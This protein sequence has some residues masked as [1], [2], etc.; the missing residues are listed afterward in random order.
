MIPIPEMFENH[1]LGIA[2]YDVPVW[3]PGLYKY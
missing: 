2:V 1:W 3:H